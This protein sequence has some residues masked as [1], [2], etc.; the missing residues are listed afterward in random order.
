MKCNILASVIF[1]SL[2]ASLSVSVAH[3]GCD[4]QQVE[5]LARDKSPQYADCFHSVYFDAA[6]GGEDHFRDQISCPDRNYTALIL[7]KT[8]PTEG[9]CSHPLFGWYKINR[10]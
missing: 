10:N 5:D 7:T 8:S 9:D 2:S 1:F 6:F 4:R 3:A